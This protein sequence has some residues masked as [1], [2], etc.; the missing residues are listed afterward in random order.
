[1]GEASEYVVTAQV[2]GYF[3]V[4]SAGAVLTNGAVTQVSNLELRPLSG[5]FD[6][7]D[8]NPNPEEYEPGDCLASAYTNLADIG[9]RLRVRQGV[10]EIRLKPKS[11]L[12]E[13]TAE[14]LP[15]R[16]TTPAPF[17]R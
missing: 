8:P 2:T 3:A 9:V 14:E 15:G 6:L 5:D 4:D 7:C 13:A 16:R 12:A 11:F 1:M 10:S 17:P